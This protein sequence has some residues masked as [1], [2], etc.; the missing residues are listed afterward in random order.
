ML[1]NLPP[2]ASQQTDVVSAKVFINGNVL[3]NE[4]L[5]A[6]LSV[7]KSFNKIAYA[8]VTLLDGSASDRNFS[9][10]ENDLF[11]PGNEIKIQLGYHGDVNTVFEGIIVK[12][13]IKVNCTGDSSLTLMAKDK[14]IKLTSAR[15]S[16]YYINKTD[17]DAIV[18]IASAL[19]P[20]VESTALSHKQLVQFNATDW[21]FIVTR[22]EANGMMVLTD[23]NKLI[24]KK[25]STA[26]APVITATYGY[27]IF[28]LDAEMDARLQFQSVTS[29]AWD[30]AQ[31]ELTESDDG[32]ALFLDNGNIP[33]SELGEVLGF[34][35]KL[36]HIGNLDAQELQ[37][38]SD[39]YAMRNYLNK[40]AGRIKISG[41][42]NVKPGSLV[43][44]E[45]MG[46]RF[47]GN[48][49]VTGILHQ[50]DGSWFTDI[51]FGWRDD[52][53]YKKEDVMDIPAG[54]LLPGV[55]GLHI[56]LVLDLDNNDPD[57]E[58]RVKVHVPTITASNEGV[59][60]RVACVD[61]GDTRGVY[62]RPQA[63]D[64][65]ILGFLEDDP[66]QPVIIG[67]LNSSNKPAPLDVANQQYGIVTKE[68]VKL[69]FDDNKKELSIIVPAS[70]GE[71]KI[72]LSN[73][74]GT[75]EI[76]DGS[77]NKITMGSSGIKLDAAS[78][79]E[80]TSQGTVKIQGAM[81]NIN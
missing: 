21:D 5:L 25:P 32:S 55:N 29:K 3:S 73:D 56:G 12:H 6:Q 30:P 48:V 37:N 40:T 43:A 14:A 71:Q 62:F 33:V 78:G 67:L 26:S 70:S 47:N 24:V 22:A 53:F 79:I 20:D 1:D 51:Q 57:G 34:E 54:G 81:V 39:A 17:S 9:L 64:E 27:N 75:I 18:Q 19:Q 15:K 35:V 31:Q 63:N 74:A 42:A 68:G 77:Q 41:N 16:N 23:D 52:W 45:G 2:G 61:A 46:E 59:W 4:M 13:C 28:D 38:W 80:I 66:R 50:Y 69:I 10:S 44:I 72:V 49:F 76:S 58:N 8:K 36:N 60:A 7:N 65:V 11:K